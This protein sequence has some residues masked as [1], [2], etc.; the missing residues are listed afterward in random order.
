MNQ[1]MRILGVDPGLRVTGYGLVQVNN[2]AT[3][4]PSFEL[5][6]AGIIKTNLK[7]GIAER[8]AKIYT[9]LDTIAHEY[10]P[11]QIVIE[12][13][14]AHYAHPQTAILMGHARGVVCLLSGV[15]KIP[16]A[17]IPSTHVKKTISGMGHAKKGQVARMIEHY[18]NVKLTNAPLDAT[19][20]LAIALSFIFNQRVS[21]KEKI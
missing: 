11:T 15:K 8:L 12:K 7:D 17:S 18:L 21:S 2:S 16:L 9:T 6:E 13:L 3:A 4:S 1:T 5:L 20:A 10:E 14:F 19:D